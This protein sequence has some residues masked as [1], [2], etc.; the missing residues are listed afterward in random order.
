MFRCG[1]WTYLFIFEGPIHSR[2]WHGGAARMLQPCA[3]SWAEYTRGPFSFPGG[4]A[5]G[6]S[7]LPATFLPTGSYR[8]VSDLSPPIGQFSKSAFKF[9][10]CW[11]FFPPEGEGKSSFCVRIL[12]LVC[13]R[14]KEASHWAC[15]DVNGFADKQQ[16]P[17]T[18]DLK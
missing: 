11:V 18:I 13:R 4:P 3:C 8:K 15:S 1:S 2:P 12:F 7:Q 5:G 6:L 9:P 10:W 14:Q 17:G 16:P